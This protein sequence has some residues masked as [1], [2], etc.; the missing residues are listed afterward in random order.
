MS[1]EGTAGDQVSGGRMSAGRALRERCG[2]GSA[3]AGVRRGRGERGPAPGP[4][5]GRGSPALSSVGRSSVWPLGEQGKQG[6][7]PGRPG[8][9]GDAAGAPARSALALPAQGEVDN[10]R[11]GELRGH[12]LVRSRSLNT[13]HSGRKMEPG[14]AVYNGSLRCY[15]K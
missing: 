6:A 9:G 5:P 11:P 8:P 13:T 14:E 1:G 3:R 10:G 4:E 12:G 15:V 7:R 2:V